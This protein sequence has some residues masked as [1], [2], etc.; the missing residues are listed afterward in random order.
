[1]LSANDVDNGFGGGGGWFGA[2]VEAIGYCQH[3]D[4]V[5]HCALAEDLFFKTLFDVVFGLDHVQEWEQFGRVG[6]GV[7]VGESEGLGCGLELV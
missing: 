3:V 6:I 2:S 7:A 5:S 1:M 4:L